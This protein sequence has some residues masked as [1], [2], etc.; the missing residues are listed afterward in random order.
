[1]AG[2]T[3]PAI[4]HPL[5]LHELFESQVDATPD[6]VALGCGDREFTYAELDAAA[7]RLARRLRRAGARPGTFVGILAS[8]SELPIIGVVACLKA[9]AA[10]VPI[11]PGYP[12]ERVRHIAA[13][14]GLQLCMTDSALYERAADILGVDRI[15]PIDDPECDR[16]ISPSR[17]TPEESGVVPTDL[18]YV[19]YTSGSTGRPKGVMTEHRHV[20]LF[21]DAF[22]KVCGTGRDDRIYQGFSLS[23]DGS[24]EEIWMA[25]SN[26]STLVV[27]PADAPRFGD[28]LGQYLDDLGITYFSTVPTMLSTMAPCIPSL[29]TVVLSGEVCSPQL[30]KGWARDGLRILNVYGPTEATVN[31]TVFDCRPD[32]PVRIGRPLDGYTVQIVDEA[33]RPLP[34]GVPGELLICSDTLARGYFNEPGLT[35]DRFVIMN[36]L[37]GG[38]RRCYRTGDLAVWR[39]DG[40]LE[41]LGRADGQ[42]KIRGYR[43]ELSEIE[44][45]LA[46]HPEIRSASVRLFQRDGLQELAA[47]VVTTHRHDR[48]DTSEVL[49]L[50]ESRVPPYMIP[51]FLDVV[52]ELPRTTS[53]KVDRRALPQ[54]VCP[55][56]RES[57]DA[58]RPRTESER[59]IAEVWAEALGIGDV[60]A[61]ADF[62]LDLGGHSLVAAQTVT[63]IR[64]IS[65]CPLTVRNAY[66]F[67][68]VQRLAAHLDGLRA[69]VPPTGSGPSGAS[70]SPSSTSRE[71]FDSTPRWRR[72]GTTMLQACS[73]YLL[74][75]PVMLPT[76][77]VFLLGLGWIQGTV[78]T[79][80][81]LV[82]AL[83][84][85][86]ILTWPALLA[87]SIAAKWILIGRYKLGEHKLWTAYYF[88]WWL[89]N[90]LAAYSGAGALA[91]TP[92][93]PIYFRLMGARVGPRCTL[94]TTQCSAWDLV[95]IGADS[96]IGADTQM[97]GYRVEDGILRIGRVDIGE[98]C[99]IGIHS[100]LGLDVRMADDSSLDD[101][102]LLPDG[103]VVP[104]GE[105]RQGSPARRAAVCRPSS[106]GRPVPQSTARR[107]L[108]GFAHVIATDLL[109]I[110]MM[111]P[112]L[113]FLLAYWF[114][115]SRGGLG[116]GALAMAVSVPAGVVVYSLYIAGLK[117]VVLRRI[118]PGTYPVLSFIYLRKWL[119]DGLMA[120]TRGLLLPVYTTLYLPPL[121]RLLGAKIGPR[122]EI[123]TVW[124]FSPELIDVEAESFFA[125]GSIIGGRRTDRGVFQVGV[126]RIGRRSFVGNGAV[127]PVGKSLG[128]GCLLGVQSIPP[129]E[130]R[131]TPDGSEWLGSPSFPLTH[132]VKVDKFDTTV[133]F[134][135]TR[136]L[137]IERAVIDAL[138][139]LIPGY[140]GL[141][142][143]A[144]TVL[145]LYL[146]YRDI[147]LGVMIAL[148]PV[149]GLA[150]GFAA[151]IFVAGLKKCV[152][153]TYRPEI[154][155]LWSRYVW[156]N[157]M[158][159]GA[160]ES[161]FAPVVSTLLGTPF[162]APFLRLMG[163]RIGRHTF[164]ATTLFSEWD[165]VEIGDHVALNHGVVVQNHLFED[166]VFKSS[167]QTIEDEAS[168]G[169]MSIVLY[170]SVVRRGGVVG[171]LSLVMK[172][173]AIEERTRWQGIP[174]VQVA[175]PAPIV[176]RLT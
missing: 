70:E 124:S 162:V 139:I 14:L 27:P 25:F 53:G 18:A 65:G 173:E 112:G 72:A 10:Y 77:I 166:R 123:S 159:N 100:A 64:E 84:V 67:T 2:R 135:P 39:D 29:R 161:I 170:D 144:A 118:P 171:P 175:H 132:R 150:Y 1:M 153:G 98:R 35:G 152:M 54:P 20:S 3:A 47:H 133:T 154:R 104:P 94:N 75:V 80:R 60:S 105:G 146:L 116:V 131:S 108:F 12:A 156:L 24:V 13:E 30:V 9:G 37:G 138:R 4:R 26:G 160:Y 107:V 7:N 6:A 15:F 52:D 16:S 143:L 155:P 49:A 82:L 78:S 103:D 157:E 76:T 50:L 117:K 130:G 172:G 93:L 164:I 165:L 21:V 106:D 99:F 41:F 91:G 113:A 97:L 51:G 102:S 73:L 115:F 36:D 32:E 136:R 151:A 126:N 114:A 90:R 121:L 79:A 69:A 140:L 40:N 59:L 95:S 163:C 120:T 48:L 8:R 43:V 122:A 129:L 81:L 145:T 158:I 92:L 88:R 96:S 127:M 109:T 168:I 149:V 19:I 85:V 23:F 111:V 87:L 125:D 148:S 119:S 33:L 101:Q 63:K 46:E 56:V 147:S 34:V 22:N 45:V 176:S 11:D 28:E 71:R 142:T 61:T 42:V 31:T 169:N 66:E 57:D 110:V 17:M 38:S 167:T 68:T 137:Y 62:F 89:V 128:D 86:P 141:L 44:A 58:I 74:S 83:I 174:T 5:C 55:L 134:R